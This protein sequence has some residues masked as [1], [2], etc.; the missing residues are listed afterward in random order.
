MSR[1]FLCFD[2]CLKYG[3]QTVPYIRCSKQ[4]N[5][6]LLTDK[7][8]FLINISGEQFYLEINDIVHDLDSDSIFIYLSKICF[9]YSTI[10]DREEHAKQDLAKFKEVI[11]ASGWDT[12]R[13]RQHN[14]QKEEYFPDNLV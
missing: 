10:A 3:E 8:R 2:I 5:V 4:T 1:K 12:T 14:A 9:E 7:Q 11:E 13:A 6:D